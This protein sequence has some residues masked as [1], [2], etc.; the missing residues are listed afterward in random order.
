MHPT[1]KQ[2][3]DHLKRYG[4]ASVD[5]LARALGLARITVRQHLMALE[6]DRLVTSREVRRS[7]GRPHHLYA[8]SAAGHD[9]YPKRYDRLALLLLEEAGRLDAAAL[10]GLSAGEKRRALLGQALERAAAHYLPH[11]EG[12]PLPQRVAALARLM[13]EEG[14][15]AEWQ[16]TEEGFEIRDYNCLYF[17]VARAHQEV[18]QWHLDLLARLLGRPVHCHQFMAQ[19]AHCCRFVVEAPD[20]Q[21]G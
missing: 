13:S 10:A 2:I 5:D 1:K 6:R 8:L 9:A 16:H 20:Q 15:L 3:L 21:E 12:R 4:D 18:C 11:L 19:G 14:A 7:S 17:Q